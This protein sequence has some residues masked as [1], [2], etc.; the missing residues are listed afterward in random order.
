[1]PAS[2]VGPVEAA[3]VRDGTEGEPVDDAARGRESRERADDD[4]A[5]H[6]DFQSVKNTATTDVSTATPIDT[7][8]NTFVRVWLDCASSSFEAFVSSD[9]EHVLRVHGRG[10]GRD[11]ETT[12]DQREARTDERKR[13]RQRLSILD[14]DR[15]RRLHDHDWLRQGHADPLPRPRLGR[16]RH[17]RRLRSALGIELRLAFDRVVS[18]RDVDRRII[19][20]LSVDFHVRY[21][22]VGMGLDANEARRRAPSSPRWLGPDRARRQGP[23]VDTWRRGSPRERLPPHVA[24]SAPRSRAA[25]DAACHDTPPRIPRPRARSPSR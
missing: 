12:T 6:S 25:H 21:I 11:R 16:L 5:L 14:D 8:R 13:R 1:M 19:Q 17:P 9:W 23:H 2:R 3:V 20:W 10:A 18:R 24:T 7:P 22:D 15:L 4:D